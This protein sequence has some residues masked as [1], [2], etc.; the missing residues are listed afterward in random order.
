MDGMNE[1]AGVQSPALACSARI[2]TERAGWCVIPL[3]DVERR[4]HTKST[5]A[6]IALVGIDNDTTPGESSG[7][8][9]YVRCGN[10]KASYS[11]RCI[12]RIEGQVRLNK[13]RGP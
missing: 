9:V 10:S 3:S 4:I 12:L 7:N 6:R 13:R 5:V 1:R 11:G 8:L 2:V